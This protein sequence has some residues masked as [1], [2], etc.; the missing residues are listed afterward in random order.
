[1]ALF[2]YNMTCF[3]TDGSSCCFFFSGRVRYKFAS[4]W[5]RNHTFRN[6]QRAAKIFREMLEAEKKVATAPFGFLNLCFKS[7]ILEYLLLSKCG[8]ACFEK[9]KESWICKFIYLRLF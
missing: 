7:T 5:N 2:F 1:M 6:L 8:A 9:G 3:V 4:F